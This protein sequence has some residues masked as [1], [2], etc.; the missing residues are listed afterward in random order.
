M[1]NVRLVTIVV[2]LCA[3][4]LPQA[5][6]VASSDTHYVLRHEATS[7]LKPDA[8][9]RRLVTPASWWHPDHTYSGDAA[10]LTLALEAGGS[11]R[12]D[13]DGGSVE[14][15]RVL[16][17]QP[18][19]VLRM[20][21]PFGPLQAAGAYTVWTISVRAADEGGGSVVV[22]DEVASGPPS[23][24]LAELAPAVDFVKSEAIARLVEAGN[25]N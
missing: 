4:P 22:F 5:E 13:W 19:E 8:L 11:W 18:G 21:A 12:E 25:A 24:S 3:S 14:H 1:R 9:W 7:T 10:N 2:G 17:V 16:L 20:A 15:G 6:I 23:A